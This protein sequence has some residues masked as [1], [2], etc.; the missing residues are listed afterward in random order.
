[1]LWAQSREWAKPTFVHLS[2]CLF[3]HKTTPPDAAECPHFTETYSAKHANSVPFSVIPFHPTAEATDS[4]GTVKVE[5]TEL[6]EGESL[7]EPFP[8]SV[9]SGLH[10]NPFSLHFI[11]IHMC[12]L[13]S[14]PA[15]RHRVV[16]YPLLPLIETAIAPETQP[17][18]VTL[19]S[20]HSLNSP[21]RTRIPDIHTQAQ[22]CAYVR[23]SANGLR[24]VFHSPE[25]RLTRRS[26]K[27][28]GDLGHG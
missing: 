16:R 13:T 6:G 2:S 26:E 18:G 27:N 14:P 7:V 22:S 24:R 15:H 8:P 20:P 25:S 1:M 10:S 12:S 11:S 4:I 5:A 3:P 28:S 17:K 9:H 19:T 21:S 23:L